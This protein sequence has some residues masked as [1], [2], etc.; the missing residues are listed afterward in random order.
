MI[1]A[2]TCEHWL[3]KMLA[4][5]KEIWPHL[6]ETYGEQN[7]SVWFNR[8]QIF[9]LACSEL[10]AYQGGDTWGVSHYLFEKPSTQ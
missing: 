6:V 8:W 5:K 2:V 1:K 4:H 10:F 9:Y 3:S 7:A